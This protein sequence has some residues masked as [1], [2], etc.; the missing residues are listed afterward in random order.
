MESELPLFVPLSALTDYFQCSVCMCNMTATTITVC[1][2]RFCEK[3]ISEW[4]NRQ[5]KCP[6]CNRA[7]LANQLM[8]DHQF[9]SLLSTLEQEKTKAETKYFETLIEAASNP[10]T[11]SARPTNPVEDVLKKHLKKGLIEHENYFQNLK[12]SFHTKMT[13]LETK[14]EKDILELHTHGLSDHEVELQTQDLRS[15]LE[16]QKNELSTELEKCAELIAEAY[17]KYLTSHIPSLDVLP[18]K[19]T[20]TLAGKNIQVPDVLFEPTHSLRQVRDIVESVMIK[21][22]NPVHRWGDD[23]RYFL[24]GPFAKCS[25]CEMES[26]IATYFSSGN[27][28]PDVQLLTEEGK[29]GLQYGIK[30]GSVIVISGTVQLESDLPKRCFVDMFRKGD[31]SQ[32]VDYF[33]CNTCSFKWICRSCMEACHQGHSIVPYIMQHRPNWA[34]C[35]CPKKK[36]C[37]IQTSG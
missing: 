8:K 1:G 37:K 21:R 34:C 7:L 35:Y 17:D 14:T 19:A 20:I 27:L 26:V 10:E 33:S 4:V 32:H 11:E 24:F 22:R 18:V 31:N 3:C 23:V 5:H 30:P 9:D 15:S 6:C 13:A 12:K 36:T 25:E 16:R 29:L 28:L 2:H